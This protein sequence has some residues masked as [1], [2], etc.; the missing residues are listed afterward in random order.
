MT[1]GT[2]QEKEW[3]IVNPLVDA[4]MA[5]VA[6]KFNSDSRYFL[7]VKRKKNG[8]GEWIDTNNSTT[9]FEAV[10]ATLLP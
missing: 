4:G 2:K 1:T 9:D 8:K 5:C 6:D 3:E 7:A 10:K